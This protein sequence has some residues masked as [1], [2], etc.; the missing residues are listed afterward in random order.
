M[1]HAAELPRMQSGYRRTRAGLKPV[2]R[3]APEVRAISL[4]YRKYVG[5]SEEQAETDEHGHGFK[6]ALDPA[7]SLGDRKVGAQVA[8]EQ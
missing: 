4:R 7:I 8:A 6:S 1:F 5:L 2:L 3:V